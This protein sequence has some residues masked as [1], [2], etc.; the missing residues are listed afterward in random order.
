MPTRLV[1]LS[2][3]DVD[4]DQFS[5]AH[6]LR[7]IVAQIETSQEIEEEGMDLKQRFG[8]KGLMANRN[9]GQIFR[10]PQDTSS[11]QPPSSSPTS[12]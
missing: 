8:L 9:K 6:S 3:S 10:C 1:E 7:L 2:D 11:C 4:L 12:H 5:V